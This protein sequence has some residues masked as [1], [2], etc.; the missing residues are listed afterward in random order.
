MNHS[1]TIEMADRPENESDFSFIQGEPRFRECDSCIVKAGSPTLC[2]G[3]LHNRELIGK[4]EQIINE[5]H[6]L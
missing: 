1:V 4:Y 5:T 3:C 2:S 6:P